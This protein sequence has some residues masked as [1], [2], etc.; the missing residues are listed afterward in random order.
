[1]KT[2]KNPNCTDGAVFIK[3]IFR[4]RCECKRMEFLNFF[5]DW[6]EANERHK[7]L[8]KHLQNDPIYFESKKDQ[9]VDSIE[10]MKYLVENHEELMKSKT[11]LLLKGVPETGKTQWA[12][13]FALEVLKT[14]DLQKDIIPFHRF[15]FLP[16]AKLITEQK[17]FDKEY[18]D[19]L[20]R[21]V[22]MSDVVIIDD[23]GEELDIPATR[24][25]EDKR[26]IEVLNVLKNIVDSQKGIL[27]VTTNSAKI[28]NEYNKPGTE[29]LHSRLFGDIKTRQTVL[30]Y[31]FLSKGKRDGLESETVK[32]MKDRFKK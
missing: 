6:S 3:G 28:Q 11:V 17:L 19:E 16:L 26:K 30:E 10:E 5:F 18:M 32:K 12:V 20:W 24:T 22:K 14:M 29:R 8:A 1:M 23:L 4:G 2:C 31:S 9:E 15:Y 27:I 13:T 21:K 25:G 7:K